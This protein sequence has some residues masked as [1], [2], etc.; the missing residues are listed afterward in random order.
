M[1]QAT[2]R[3]QFRDGKFKVLVMSDIHFTTVDE[4][5]TI[6]Q[7]Q[8][9]Y[10]NGALDL[11]KPDL[12]ILDGDNV[13]AP[14]K[15]IQLACIDAILKPIEARGIYFALVMGNH[16]GEQGGGYGRAE[17][18]ALYQ[19]Y[20]KCLAVIGPDGV[21]GVGNYNILLQNTIG[22]K[23]VF[24]LWC[25]DSRDY[26]KAHG[27]DYGYVEDDQIAWY[28]AT[29]AQLATQNGGK[30]LPSIVFQ[31]TP[32]PEMYALLVP[33]KLPRLYA[34]KGASSRSNRYWTVNKKNKTIE[35]GFW[36]PPCAPD[37]NNG[38]FESWKKAGDVKLAIFGH[39][40]SNTF[41]G[42]VDGIRLMYAG[43]AG[44]QVYGNGINYQSSLLIIDEATQTVTRRLIRFIDAV[45]PVAKHLK[46]SDYFE[47]DCWWSLLRL[48][49][50]P[51]WRCARLALGS[52]LTN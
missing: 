15:E 40:H 16:D 24:N 48:D 49:L 20:D 50:R 27:G 33:H 26:D 43:A 42:E 25:I 34:E 52:L 11:A 22:T 13:T 2:R 14:T 51:L 39:D 6:Y 36:E 45:G 38:Q 44:M 9:A 7:D 23:D 12:V 3:L 4:S 37:W 19:K 8:I 1:T 47:K 10:F 41:S 30:A 29:A 5:S 31:H 46:A 35:G 18:M 28:E 32:V 17:Q 21:S